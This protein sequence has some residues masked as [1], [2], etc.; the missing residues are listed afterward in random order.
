MTELSK[1]K[2]IAAIE[3]SNPAWET[4]ECEAK[5]LGKSINQHFS[6]LLE[7]LFMVQRGRVKRKVKTEL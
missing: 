6:D 5:F 1:S 7:T 3:L 2:R 4:F